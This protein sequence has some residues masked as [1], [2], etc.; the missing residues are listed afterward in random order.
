MPHIPDGPI[1][2]T[3]HKPEGAFEAV[4]GSLETL[5]D[6]MKD[7]AASY[8]AI[9]ASA[10]RAADAV[11]EVRAVFIRKFANGEDSNAS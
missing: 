5:R 2:C 4:S 1:T 7:V 11:A 3:S 9:S 6:T 8:A 10:D